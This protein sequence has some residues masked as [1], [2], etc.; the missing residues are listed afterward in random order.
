MSKVPSIKI[1]TCNDVFLERKDFSKSQLELFEALCNCKGITDLE[2][3]FNQFDAI[4]L[5]AITDAANHIMTHKFT[6][7]NDTINS[8]KK[9]MH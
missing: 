2:Q 8:L 6:D 5:L 1:N 7:L 3:V 9:G 4:H